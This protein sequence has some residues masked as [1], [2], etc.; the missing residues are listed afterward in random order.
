MTSILSIPTISSL[1]FQ[2]DANGVGLWI[3]VK[4]WLS[5][6]NNNLGPGDTITGVRKFRTRDGNLLKQGNETLINF[7]DV[8]RYAFV[9]QSELRVCRKIAEEVEAILLRDVLTDSLNKVIVLPHHSI[10]KTN[11]GGPTLANR[12]RENDN[13][14]ADEEETMPYC[15]VDRSCESTGKF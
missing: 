13:I 14:I 4:V 2:P 5:F 6:I 9:R 11:P 10:P 7:S 15:E 12:G 8:I 3:P 1:Q